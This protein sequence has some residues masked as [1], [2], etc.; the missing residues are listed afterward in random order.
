MT[1]SAGFIG[2]HLLEALLRARPAA[3]SAWT[4]SRPA[5]ARNLERGAARRSAPRPGRGTASSKATSSTSR[6]AARPATGVDIVLHQAAL[7]SVPRSIAD[8][9]AHPRSQRHRLPQHAGRRARRRGASASSTPPRAPPTA[10]TPALPKVED[11]IGRPLSPY[12]VTKYVERA[13]CRRVRA[14]LR[15]ADDR[16][17]LLQRVRRAPGSRGRLCRGDPALDR[18]MLARRAGRI[19][20]DGETSRDFCY[21]ANVVQANLLRR[22]SST[23]PQRAEPGLQRRGGRAHDAQPAARAPARCCSPRKASRRSPSPSTAPFRAGDVRHSLADISLGTARAW[24]TRQRT[25]S[26]AGSRRHCRGT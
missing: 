19:N 23:T 4:T 12:A 11:M 14:L 25:L 9:L 20:G 16:P 18:A 26:Q 8:P 24:A 10:T 13:V 6:P 5:T 1:G 22:D 21:V 17:A 3:W 2:S 7:G 15:H